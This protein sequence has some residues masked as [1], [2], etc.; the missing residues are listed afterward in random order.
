M[1]VVKK[2]PEYTVYQKRSERYAVKGAGKKWLNGDEKVKVLLAEKL[3]NVA[4]PKPKAEESSA[5]SA[6]GSEES[7]SEAE[8]E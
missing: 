7:S 6:E 2:T 8:S 5:E 4:A 1:K 3:I